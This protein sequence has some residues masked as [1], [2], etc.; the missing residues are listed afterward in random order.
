MGKLQKTLLAL[1]VFGGCAGSTMASAMPIA[2]LAAPAANVETVRWI[3][4]PYRCFW[5][6]N[7]YSYGYYGP[8]RVFY[9][10][11]RFY[12]GWRGGWRGRRW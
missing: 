10:G 3:C 11:P 6:P 8:P 4:G 5:R 7:F 2:P 12:G 1:V 9:G